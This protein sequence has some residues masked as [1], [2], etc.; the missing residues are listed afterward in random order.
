MIFKDESR[1]LEACFFFTLKIIYFIVKEDFL[2]AVIL[3]EFLEEKEDTSQEEI[4]CVCVCVCARTHT[5]AC[6]LGISNRE[7][8]MCK[9]F[10]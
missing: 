10:K 9:D 4:V 1:E 7:N 6:S 3:D 8:S 2:K 5:P